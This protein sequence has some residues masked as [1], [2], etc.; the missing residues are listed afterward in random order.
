MKYRGFTLIELMAAVTVLSILTVLFWG[1]EIRAR[2]HDFE[3]TQA[4]VTIEEMRR[5][6]SMAQTFTLYNNGNWP[7]A[8]ADCQGSQQYLALTTFDEYSSFYSGLID[9]TKNLPFSIG[10]GEAA[11][12]GQYYFKCPEWPPGSG[13]RPEFIIYLALGDRHPQWAEYMSNQ[14]AGAVVVRNSDYAGLKVSWP[15]LS[16]IPALSA[17]LP[18][19][20]SL[21]MLGN[22]DMGGN[23]IGGL[24]DVSLTEGQTLGS[25]PILHTAARPGNRIAKPMCPDDY[26]P[27]IIV[28]PKEVAHTS[29]QPIT[30]FRV[31]ANDR[32]E[33]WD[34]KSEVH[35]VSSIVDYDDHNKVLAGVMVK[36]A[37]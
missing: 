16:A 17:L 2:V 6:G 10:T 23:T 3:Q 28:V 13:L 11:H 8:V 34:I 31:W 5:L 29:G 9:P 21:S 1:P 35:S 30:K 22:L 18:R 32:G 33:A 25:V 19:D 7:G 15:L 36:C 27:Q 12:L 24:G 26:L 37:L 4:D 14:L 20:G